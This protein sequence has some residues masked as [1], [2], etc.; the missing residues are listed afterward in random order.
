MED[1]FICPRPFHNIYNHPGGN[2]SPCCWA[3]PENSKGDPNS[4]L[5]IDHFNGEAFRRLRKEM[6]EGKKTDFLY[7]YCKYCFDQ[8][9]N[10]NISPR[11]R[12]DPISTEKIFN[13]FNDDGSL[14]N[15][16]KERFLSVSINIFGNACNLECHGCDP[17]SSSSRTKAIKKIYPELESVGINPKLFSIDYKNNSFD[18][19]NKEHFSNIIDQLLKYSDIITNIHFVGG[20]PMLMKHHFL[21]LNRLIEENK[22]KQINLNY[23]SNMTLMSLNEMKYYFDNFKMTNIQWSVDALKEKNYWLRYPTDWESTTK[24]V[25][26]IQS[27]FKKT[28]KGSIVATIT[29]SI[30]GI[31]S[32]RKTYNWLHVRGLLNRKNLIFNIITQPKFLRTRNLPDTLK[33]KISPDIKLIS[34]YHYLDLLKPRDQHEFELAIKYFDLLDQSRG[35]D[36]RS[37]FP[38]V[39]KYLN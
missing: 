20:E 25:F 27:Y 34:E 32:L 21:L 24:N 35:T 4:I 5:P 17:K 29:P 38:E 31:P 2:Y 10:F 19:N 9:E 16:I 11:T 12:F 3:V 22:S 15:D 18:L 7:S 6:L 30:L 36:W 1:K 26:D 28:R 8:E 37:I 13:I 14:K 23:V 33:E 39:S